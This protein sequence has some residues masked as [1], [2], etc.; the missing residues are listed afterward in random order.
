MP[1][2]SKIMNEDF[3][4]VIPA[5]YDSSRFPGKSLA[6]IHGKPMIQRV[7]EAAVDAGAS[8]VVVATDSTLIGMAAEDFDARVCMTLEEHT[9]GTDRLSEVVDKLGWSDDTVVVNLQGD[10]PLTPPAIINQVAVNLIKNNDADCA[11]L[12]TTLSHDDANDPNIVKVVADANGFALYFSRATIPYIRD[13]EDVDISKMMYKRHIGLYAYTVGV[14][15]KFH[16]LQP[17][18]LEQAEKLEQLRLMWNGMRIHV[19]QAAAIPGHGVDTPAD[20][21]RVRAAIA[22]DY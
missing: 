12:Y 1:D 14:L 10:E 17:C 2:T 8:E 9:S 20:L 22:P 6:D 3:K 16:T 5:R 13:P 18:E 21:E 15:K 7:Y 11:T 4:I 19:A